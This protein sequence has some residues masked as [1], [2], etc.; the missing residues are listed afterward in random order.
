MII[1]KR[2]VDKI[3]DNMTRHFKDKVK[4]NVDTQS[5]KEALKTSMTLQNLLLQLEKATSWLLGNGILNSSLLNNFLHWLIQCTEF[6][7]LFSNCPCM[8]VD[9]IYK[10]SVYPNVYKNRCLEV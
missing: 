3:I 9:S 10:P 4:V 1:V 2:D 7:L 5:L 8:K 6:L